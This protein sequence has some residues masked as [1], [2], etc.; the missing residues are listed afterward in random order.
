MIWWWQMTMIVDGC[1][2]WCLRFV[3]W[4][5]P[6]LWQLCCVVLM[7]MIRMATNGD[8]K[9]RHCQVSK[10]ALL[11]CCKTAKLAWGRQPSRTWW[12]TR[13]VIPSSWAG[14]ATQSLQR[15]ASAVVV[16]GGNLAAMVDKL[17]FSIESFHWKWPGVVVSV[18]LS[19]SLPSCHHIE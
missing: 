14:V 4:R 9:C 10:P 7:L 17:V 11:G 12:T 8:S 5:S 6:R 13:R 1:R 15:G 19:S 16:V 3:R 18:F 2:G